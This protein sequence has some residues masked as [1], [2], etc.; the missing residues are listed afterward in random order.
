VE[1]GEHNVRAWQRSIGHVPQQIF[2]CDD[3][4][5]RNIALGLPDGE[6]DRA[7]VEQAARIARLH[8][9][10]AGLPKGYD[11]M[12]GDRGIRLS[13]G[14][15]QRIGI[16]R[17]L[18]DDPDLLVLDEATSALD[19]VT[20]NAVFEALQALAGRKTIVMV[21][22][23]LSTVRGCDLI[24]VMEQGRIVERGSHDELMGT[25]QRF[26]ALATASAA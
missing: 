26:R 16:A 18:Y 13:G 24:C 11:T 25:S 3:T 5:A 9:F 12:V 19:N 20:E 17:A 8:E 4:I 15:R 23:R 1:V 14:Q 21:A 6:L 2:L 10:V 22:H 7:R